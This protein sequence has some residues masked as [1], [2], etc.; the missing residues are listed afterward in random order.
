M[1]SSI[2]VMF[3]KILVF[4]P[5]TIFLIYLVLRYGGKSLD[6]LQGGRYMKIIERVSFSK[7]SSILIVAI[8]SKYYLIS[9]TNS[10]N[11]I[12]KDIEEDEINDF[13]RNKEDKLTS[14]FQSKINSFINRGKL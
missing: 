3:L 6:G 12:L 7:D 11:E 10:K 14:S 1:E 2:F 8:G 5:F 4:L 13:L 9:S